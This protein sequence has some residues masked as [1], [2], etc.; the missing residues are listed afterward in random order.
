[1]TATEPDDSVPASHRSFPHPEPRANLAAFLAP[2]GKLS[3]KSDI[4]GLR[5][6]LQDGRIIHFRPSGNA[7]GMR[8]YVEAETPEAAKELLKQG[9]ELIRVWTDRAA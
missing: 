4:D 2:I 6:A 5:I 1:M 3:N 7:P 8:C 9:L